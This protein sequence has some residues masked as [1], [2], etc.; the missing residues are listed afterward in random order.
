MEKFRDNHFRAYVS[1]GTQFILVFL[2]SMLLVL[3][4]NS[5]STLALPYH[6]IHL[7]SSEQSKEEAKK[8]EIKGI[9]QFLKKFPRS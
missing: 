4:L 9:D 5:Y 7:H 8:E 6:L 1:S 2:L 3:P